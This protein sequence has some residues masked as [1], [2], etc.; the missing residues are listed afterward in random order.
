MTVTPRALG[1]L[2]A[3]EATSALVGFAALVVLAR[4]LGPGP[5]ARV[6]FAGAIAAVMLVWVRGGIESIALR[7]AS[8]R[9]R[10]IARWSGVLLTVKLA[11]ASVALGV[12]G[13]AAAFA[14]QGRGATILAAGLVLIPS[15]LLI[16]LGPRANGHLGAVAASQVVRALGLALATWFLVQGP[17]A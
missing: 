1:G 17:G 15:A 9:P 5:L 10:L 3:A 12:V 13:C 14:G 11:L 6:E 8:R 2:L 4:R 7:E 16:D